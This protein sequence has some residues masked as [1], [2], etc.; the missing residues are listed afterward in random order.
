MLNDGQLD[1]SLFIEDGLHMNPAGYHIWQEVLQP[2][3]DNPLKK[4]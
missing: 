1:Q 4:P 3:I 2:L